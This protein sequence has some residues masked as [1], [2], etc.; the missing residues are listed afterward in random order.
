MMITDDRGQRISVHDDHT[1][2][3]SLSPVDQVRVLSDEIE[4]KSSSRGVMMETGFF[5][6]AGGVLIGV[7]L[8]NLVVRNDTAVI[9]TIIIALGLGTWVYAFT[10]PRRMDRLVRRLRVERARVWDHGTACRGCAFDLSGIVAEADGC[11]VCPECGG[12]WRVRTEQG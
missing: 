5:V 8:G 6:L 4:R 7:G 12:A 3:V 2:I 9:A 11:T 1:F 10:H